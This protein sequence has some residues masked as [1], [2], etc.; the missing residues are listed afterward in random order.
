[1][2][3]SS[4][5]E[6]RAAARRNRKSSELLHPGLRLNEE[7]LCK[8]VPGRWLLLAASGSLHFA[9][10][11]HRDHVLQHRQRVWCNSG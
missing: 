11:L 2:L 7:V 4:G 5:P 8:Y 3:F 10:R 6:G 9:D 1:M